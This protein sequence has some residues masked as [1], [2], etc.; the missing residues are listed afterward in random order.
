MST[1]SIWYGHVP[2]RV[3]NELGRGCLIAELGIEFTELLSDSLH[4]RMPVDARTRQPAGVLHGGASVAFA[5]TLASMAGFLAVD[6]DRFHV[7]G[8]EINANHLG[9]VAGGWVTG[10]V[11]PVHC[12]RRSHVW[13]VRISDPRERLVCIS[14]CTLAVIET[15]AVEAC[16]DPVAQPVEAPAVEL[17]VADPHLFPSLVLRSEAPGAGRGQHD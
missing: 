12:G 15:L 1:Q 14:R 4:G 2:L 10:V 13:E 6:R 5:E 16:R 17:L 9:P 7:A 11:R 3:L 8:M